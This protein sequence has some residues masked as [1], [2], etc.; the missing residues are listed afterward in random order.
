MQDARVGIELNRLV[1]E[2]LI[3]IWPGTGTG[4]WFKDTMAVMYCEQYL[5]FC[6][7]VLDKLYCNL[8]VICIFR[9]P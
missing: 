2:G 5:L 6:F 1:G 8:Y 3:I 4:V 7:M 9:D